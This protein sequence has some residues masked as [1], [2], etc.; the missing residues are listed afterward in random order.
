M[1]MSCVSFEEKQ[2]LRRETYS[3]KLTVYFT[4]LCGG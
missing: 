1:E 4:A 3:Y 2:S